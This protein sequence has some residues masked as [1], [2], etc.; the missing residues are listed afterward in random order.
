MPPFLVTG[1]GS[2]GLLF[3]P[4]LPLI[5]YGLV[6]GASAQTIAAAKS[7]DGDME[8]I[9][10]DMSRFL[11]AGVVPGLV[12][13]RAALYPGRLRRRQAQGAAPPVLYQE[14]ARPNHQMVYHLWVV[15]PGERAAGRFGES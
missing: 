13:V 12:L 5:V 3:P 15:G 11:L 14:P 9:T 6:Y 1:T 7:G 2:V 8:L 10:W 4:A